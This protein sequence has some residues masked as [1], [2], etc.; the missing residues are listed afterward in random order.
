MVPLL[1]RDV[2][3]LDDLGGGIGGGADVADL[4]LGDE[5]GERAERLL[6][7]GPGIPAVHLIEVDPVGLQALQRGLHLTKDPAPR[8]AG[9]IW[10]PPTLI[11]HRAVELGGENDVLAASPREGLADDRL[12]LP[13]RVDIGGVDE[14]DAPIEHAVD[15]A[16]TGIVIA[17][18]PGA[19]HHRAEA[20]RGDVHAGAP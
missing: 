4:A 9:L 16:N 18:P 2:L 1:A 15:D 6:V 3:G 17:L 10:I 19:E 5:V 20:Q 14:V 7:I 8:V 11:A 13:A 12:G